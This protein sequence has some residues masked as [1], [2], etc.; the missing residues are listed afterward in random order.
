M[1]NIQQ[2]Q[3]ANIQADYDKRRAEQRYQAAVAVVKKHQSCPKMM[4]QFNYWTTVAKI[5][6]EALAFNHNHAN[7]TSLKNRMIRESK[8]QIKHSSE[9]SKALVQ[10]CV[11]QNHEAHNG[12]QQQQAEKAKIQAD[13]D[14]KRAEQRY[15]AAVAV[16]KKHQSCP[17]KM[18]QFN[19]WTTVATI[20]DEALAFNHNHANAMKLKNRMIRESKG[21]IINSSKN[22]K[23]PYK[24][25]AQYSAQ[26]QN[27]AYRRMRSRVQAEIE[28]QLHNQQN[29]IWQ[30]INNRH[31]K[32]RAE[33]QKQT[34][35]YFQTQYETL[36]KISSV[37]HQNPIHNPNTL[38]HLSGGTSANKQASPRSGG[39][40]ANKQA[41]SI[42]LAE[43]NDHPESF[44][45][46]NGQQCSYSD[47][48][49]A[50]DIVNNSNEIMPGAHIV[51]QI[52]KHTNPGFK[53]ECAPENIQPSTP[54]AASS[55]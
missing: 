17:R 2:Q 21:Q 9:N 15:Q 48:L 35:A 14:K 18:N 6:D 29:A 10:T 16:V 32:E 27:E 45:G 1:N 4:T 34:D 28:T 50:A 43:A 3:R 7:A 42:F 55:S 41:S 20:C 19:Y 36:S 54:G 33:Y 5:C 38:T 51:N 39:T 53:W 40:S 13:Y 23:E 26:Q 24:T 49:H 30:G 31:E 22:S 44:T 25:L 12:I 52:D 11:R 46:F 8:G 47:I 37:P